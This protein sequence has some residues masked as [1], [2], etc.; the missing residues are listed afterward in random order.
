MDVTP[1][2]QHVEGAVTAQTVAVLGVSASLGRALTAYLDV[3][4]S[5]DRILG[6]DGP[7]PE[8]P[9]GK[10]EFRRADVR[11]R[12]LP[13]ALAGADTVVHLATTPSP[14]RDEDTMFAIN[15]HGTR[16]VLEAI[17]RVGARKLV[18]LSHG[19]VYGA[20]PDNDV[21][22]DESAPLRA[23]PDFS[24]SWQRLLAEDLVAD[25]AR[26][27]PDVTVT[28]LRPAMIL[29]PGLDD[30][31]ARLLEAPRLPFVRGHLPPLQVVHLDDVASAA[32]LA[33]A[34]DL[35][36]HFNVAADGWVSVVELSHL[37]SRR[38]LELP[39]EVAVVVADRLWRLGL[40]PAPPGALAYLMEPWVLSN[41]ALR[42]RG[43]T[44]AHSNRDILREFAAEH[45]RYEALGRLRVRRRNLVL[46]ALLPPAAVL[47]LLLTRR[48][49]RSRHRLPLD[50]R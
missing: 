25:W 8:M 4:A 15:V 19:A 12:L 31:V 42:A 45:H 17:E 49:A 23:N 39:E 38:V 40:S 44:P 46:A 50:S 43:W 34:Q 30:F 48:L 41:E 26:A 20:H 6:L 18:Y 9:V 24:L 21:P 36:G 35:P 16:N 32:A 13:R 37:L 11:D 7:E 2:D 1:T 29:G 5:V 47:A 3:D 33:V 27:H 22:L 10:L 28:V 14:L